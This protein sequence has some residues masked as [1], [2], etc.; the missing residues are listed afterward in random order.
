MG[1]GDR[2]MAVLG[3]SAVQALTRG[4]AREAERLARAVLEGSPR[5]AN[6]LQVLGALAL[7]AGDTAAAARHLANA[8]LAAPDHPGLLNML[9]VA[10]RRGGNVEAAAALFRRAGELGSGE[11]WFNLGNLESARGA[12][13]EAI[14]AYEAALRLAPDD[15]RA[16]AGLAFELERRHELERA[17]RHAADALRIAPGNAI[18]AVTMARVMLREGRYAEA[19]AA[20]STASADASDTNRAIALGLMGDALDRQGR[21]REAFAAFTGANQL[22]LARHAALRE[23]R[24]SPYHPGNVRALA[25]FAARAELSGW[26]VDRGERAPVFLVG[27]PRSGT[28]LLEQ[29]LAS[30]GQVRC[31]EEREC[32]S[33]TV[34]DLA[35]SPGQ[36]SALTEAEASARRGAYWAAVA[37]EGGATD[38]PVMVDKL[39]L[40]IVFLP[41]IRRLFPGAR[42]IVALRD[43]RDV[44]L[45]CFQQRFTLNP[46]MIQLLDLATAAAYYDT[47]MS[48]WDACRSRLG[49]LMHVVRYED[50]VDDLETEARRLCGFLGL[51]FDQD[52]LRFRESALRRDV[53]TPSSRQ[54][55]EPLYRRSVGRWRAYAEDLAPVLPALQRWTSALGYP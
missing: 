9:G 40:N 15:P 11:A 37:A 41:V 5:D 25:D 50:V 35:L 31:L 51:P 48:V 19:A 2:N 4:D 34:T 44:I 18:A 12:A 32:L 29:V 3:V 1:V 7:R 17:A 20:A 45:S 21:A 36:L 39:P 54:V 43:P 6:A 26:P 38:R 8:V 47:V 42:V 22:L 30:H 53:R 55:V 49:L 33:R 16:H 14:Q 27:F 13:N 23:Q 52:M 24:G 46:A 28:T 10:Q